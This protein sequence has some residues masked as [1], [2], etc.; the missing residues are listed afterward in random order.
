MYIKKMETFLFVD[1]YHK[2]ANK[3]NGVN[4][5]MQQSN[6]FHSKKEF[7]EISDRQIRQCTTIQHALAERGLLECKGENIQSPQNLL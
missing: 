7:I 2:P 5:R 4:R 1:V 6:V 3:I